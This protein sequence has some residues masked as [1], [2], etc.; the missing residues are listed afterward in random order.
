MTSNLTLYRRNLPHW[1]LD[2]CVYFIT[3]RLHESQPELVAAER[4][5]VVAAL[6]YFRDQRY[7]L[8]AFVVMN[9]HVHVLVQ[10]QNAFRLQDIMHSWKS[11]TARVLQKDFQRRGTIWQAES[12]DRIVRDETELLEKGQ[13]ILNNPLKRWP[14]LREYPWVG[15][16]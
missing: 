13:Y 11:F 15:T 3:W 8:L 7:D 14:E 10:P 6:R 12:F 2:G 1:R 4:D 5:V 9:D 16:Q